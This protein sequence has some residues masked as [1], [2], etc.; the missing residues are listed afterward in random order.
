MH[1]TGRVLRQ[2]NAD[3]NPFAVGQEREMEMALCLTALRRGEVPRVDETGAF[4]ERIAAE[5][6]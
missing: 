5:R 6:L 1:V 3:R 2:T 4:P